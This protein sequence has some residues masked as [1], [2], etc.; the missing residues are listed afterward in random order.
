MKRIIGMLT[1]LLLLS[2]M[3][4]SCAAE[5]AD[6]TADNPSASEAEA[7]GEEETVY[8]TPLDLTGADGVLWIQ[9]ADSIYL[10]A[11][12]FIRTYQVLYTVDDCQIGAYI[13]VPESEELPPLLLYHRGGYGTTGAG[14]AEKIASL[15]ECTGCAVIATNYRE[16]PPGNGKDEFCGADV[17]DSVFWLNLADNIGFA[18]RERV[19]M[20]GESRGA[21]QSLLTLLEDKKEI[22][23]AVAC[24]SGVYDL[25]HTAE[26][27]PSLQA[28][29]IDRIGGTAKELPEEYAR[30]SA[31][32]FADRINIPVL[33]IHSRYDWL[34]DYAEAVSMAE[35]LSEYGKTYE[36]RTRENNIHCI[37]SAQ[38]LTEIMAWFE[39]VTE[40]AAE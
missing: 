14:S 27:S 31:V 9:E 40:T 28:M 13:A 10:A 39:K 26:Y 18:D 22:V 16:T 4:L 33:L 2:G 20:L 32:N 8:E 6:E 34:V 15:A 17:A 11:Y 23:R 36:L 1:A 3:L 25:V 12:P 38:E 21:M 30:R 24:V 19:Y 35:K 37:Q 5:S 29:M 7:A